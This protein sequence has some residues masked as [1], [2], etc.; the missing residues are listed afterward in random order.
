VRRKK[1]DERRPVCTPCTSLELECHGYGAKPRWM[2][3]G[4]L[5]KEQALRFKQIVGHTKARK[6]RPQAQ[7]NESPE[8]SD[9][10]VLFPSELCYLDGPWLPADSSSSP[11]PL[12]VTAHAT[13]LYGNVDS[14][15]SASLANAHLADAEVSWGDLLSDGEGF[16][17]KNDAP[18]TL[19]AS[20]E[21][22]EDV[23]FM[24]FFDHVFYLQY[25]YYQ[26][27]D[28][29]ER[30]WL[31]SILR[32][33]KPAYYATLAQ[34][35]RHFLA[36]VPHNQHIAAALTLR[37]AGTTYYDLAMHGM[38]SIMAAAP[39]R[40]SLVQSVEALTALL[41]LLFLEVSGSYRRMRILAKL[42]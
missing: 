15:S 31:F 9:Q 14:I 36:T 34:S 4:T 18:L 13:S 26:T 25:P 35:E 3:N 7:T 40:A 11:A 39:D 2:D 20:D 24:H 1:C 38:Q 17:Q 23:V 33:V 16:L 5:Q 37:R 22:A 21:E 32:R 19:S 41:Q 29:R 28:G 6:G 12:H 27:R 42:R 8:S 10:M 30:G